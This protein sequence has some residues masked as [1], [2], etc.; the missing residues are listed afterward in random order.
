[1]QMARVCQGICTLPMSKH[2]QNQ[3]DPDRSRQRANCLQGCAEI[4]VFV[5]LLEQEPERAD[6]LMQWDT[7]LTTVQYST[8]TV[9]NSC[10]K[11]RRV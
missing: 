11:A 1:M 7:T 8:H 3:A 10:K 2:A 6:K 9:Y 5:H 4:A